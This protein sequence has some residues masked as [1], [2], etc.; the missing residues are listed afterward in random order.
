[1]T[2]MLA[3]AGFAWLCLLV[4]A[5]VQASLPLGWGSWLAAPDVLLLVTLF[6][7]LQ[8]RDEMGPMVVLGAALGYVGDLFHG[9]PRGMHMLAYALAALGARLAANRL[10]V[11]GAAATML[12]TLMASAGFGLL[13]TGLRASFEPEVGWEPARVVPMT[14]LTTALLAPWLFRLMGRLER[15]FVRNPRGLVLL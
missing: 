3:F 7:G 11:R 5:T 8:A 1:M 4:V 15:R 13:V 14:A 12:V 2:R 6:V 9:S 10:M